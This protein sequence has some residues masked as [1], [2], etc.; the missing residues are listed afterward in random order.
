MEEDYWLA[1]KFCASDRRN[2]DLPILFTMETGIIDLNLGYRLVVEGIRTHLCKTTWESGSVELDWATRVVVPPLP[3]G[4]LEG[5]FQLQRDRT[6]P[7]ESLFQSTGEENSAESWSMDLV[8]TMEFVYQFYTL[9][10][11]LWSP[12]PSSN[13]C[14]VSVQSEQEELEEVQGENIWVCL[15]RLLPTWPSPK[16]S[17]R[18]HMDGLAVPNYALG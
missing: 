3:E 1:S 14:P 15:F 5:A 12:G 11:N 6:Q 18:R 13:G 2:G 8:G 17:S 16:R 10:L 4:A 9:H 7:W